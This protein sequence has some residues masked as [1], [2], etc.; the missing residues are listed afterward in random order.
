M[1]DRMSLRSSVP[2]GQARSRAP[3]FGNKE[4]DEDL[5]LEDARV[6]AGQRGSTSGRVRASSA[7]A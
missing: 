6:I 3:L 5:T 7:T 2:E 4:D 1:L